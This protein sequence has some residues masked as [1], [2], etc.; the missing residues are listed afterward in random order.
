M[1]NK[2]DGVSVSSSLIFRGKIS[3]KLQRNICDPARPDAAKSSSLVDSSDS[4]DTMY[5]MSLIDTD[6]S[7]FPIDVPS[8][9]ESGQ[10]KDAEST[11]S[12]GKTCF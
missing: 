7:S 11:I 4:L 10:I 8:A 5:Y 12:R 6:I 9:N 3:E 1:Q 2:I